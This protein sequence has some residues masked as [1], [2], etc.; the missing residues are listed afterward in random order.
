MSIGSR[1]KQRRT[2]LNMSQEVFITNPYLYPNT[3]KV[4]VVY[5][6]EPLVMYNIEDIDLSLK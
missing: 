6:N 5:N 3:T 4:A 2:E 1:I